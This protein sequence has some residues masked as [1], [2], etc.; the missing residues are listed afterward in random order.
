MNSLNFRESQQD[1]KTIKQSHTAMKMYQSDL[2]EIKI[3]IV[4][5]FKNS[6]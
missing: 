2:K 6:K 3:F 4:K 5:V 1:I